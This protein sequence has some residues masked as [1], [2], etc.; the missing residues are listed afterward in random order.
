M[1]YLQIH[2]DVLKRRNNFIGITFFCVLLFFSGIINVE[3]Q[4]NYSIESDSSSYTNTTITISWSAPANRTTRSGWI[5]IYEPTDA[6]TGYYRWAYIN[7]AANSG[8]VTFTNI[9]PGTYEARFFWKWL[10]TRS[11]EHHLY[12]GR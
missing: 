7:S 6:D 1:K 3:A 4:T 5:G 8:S 9:A 12:C 10:C 11:Q 2:V